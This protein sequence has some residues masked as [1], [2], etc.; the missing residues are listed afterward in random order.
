[1]VN[2]KI[3]LSVILSVVFAAVAA[4]PVRAGAEEQGSAVPALEDIL[5]CQAGPAEPAPDTGS[6][7]EPSGDLFVPEPTYVCYAGWCSSDEQCVE[8]V[9]PDSRCVKSSGASCG[10]C[11][12]Q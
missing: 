7:A 5:S 4:F 3:A 8:W 12:E 6:Q 2:R 9:G 10:H 11:I 1:M